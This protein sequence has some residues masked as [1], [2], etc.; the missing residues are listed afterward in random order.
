[1]TTRPQF[2]F[3]S[4]L[5]MNHAA[6]H[7][8]ARRTSGQQSSIAANGQ[9]IGGSARANGRVVIFSPDMTLG[10]IGVAGKRFPFDCINN[11]ASTCGTATV[12]RR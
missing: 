1:M 2:I 10:N 3:A 9:L 6:F 11:L 4:G 12:A 5:D 8:P 7:P